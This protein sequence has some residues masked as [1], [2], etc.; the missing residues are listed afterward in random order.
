ML[1]SRGD[2]FVVNESIVAHPRNREVC[3]GEKVGDVLCRNGWLSACS[4][5]LVLNDY[6]ESRQVAAKPELD[7]CISGVNET[8]RSWRC[9]P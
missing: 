5:R 1:L 3:I 4:A 8:K 7:W 6:C 2:G 9:A